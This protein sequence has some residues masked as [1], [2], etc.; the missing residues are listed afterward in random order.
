M[1]EKT[2]LTTGL[3]AALA[4]VLFGAP[5][6]LAVLFDEPPPSR[7]KALKAI[8]ESLASMALGGLIGIGLAAPCANLLNGIVDKFLSVNPHVSPVVAGVMAGVVLTNMGP[9]LI[10]RLEAKLFS[11]ATETLG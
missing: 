10:R 9:S 5:S 2:G 8:G 11:K 6:L 1:V 7:R 3:I 4:V